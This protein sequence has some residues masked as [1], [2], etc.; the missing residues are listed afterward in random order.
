MW[1][2][3]LPI[4]FV[5]WIDSFANPH[6]AATDERR[7]VANAEY[8]GL[9]VLVLLSQPRSMDTIWFDCITTW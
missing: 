6:V 2:F 7:V 1:I 4:F 8:A 9:V 3:L 5:L